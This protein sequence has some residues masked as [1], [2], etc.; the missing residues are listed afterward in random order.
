MGIHA[1][2][3]LLEIARLQPL[4]FFSGFAVTLKLV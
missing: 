3:T 4:R 2:S 1:C